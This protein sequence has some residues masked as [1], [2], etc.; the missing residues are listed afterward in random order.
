MLFQFMDKTNID[1]ILLRYFYA[2]VQLII[3]IVG[4]YLQFY[5]FINA[6]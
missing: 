5:N 1:Q 6:P 4:L 3:D 2:I